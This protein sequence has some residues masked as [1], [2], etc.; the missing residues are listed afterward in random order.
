LIDLQEHTLEQN[1]QAQN[2]DAPLGGAK[3]R[4]KQFSSFTN[5]RHRLAC[6]TRRSP[7]E[8]DERRCGRAYSHHQD[9]TRAPSYTDGCPVVAMVASFHVFIA[10]C[11]LALKRSLSWSA[12]RMLKWCIC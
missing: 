9:F 12:R 10:L 4:E 6:R 3:I 5:T 1:R 2:P 11:D 8:D 7:V